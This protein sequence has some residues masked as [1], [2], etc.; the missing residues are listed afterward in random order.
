MRTVCIIPARGGSVRIPRKNIRPF[1][2]KPIMLYSVETAQKSMLFDEV[3][4]STDDAEISRIARRAGA[5][6]FWR[7]GTD[8]GAK[9]TQEVAAD[10]LRE[11]PSAMACVLYATAPLLDWVHLVQGY[12]MLTAH[13]NALPFAYSVDWCNND[14]GA[15]YWGWGAAF[16]DGID[17]KHG[18]GIS[19]RDDRCCDINTIEDFARAESMF[20]A[21]RRAP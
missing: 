17:L 11:K 21:L 13:P 8:D 16:V 15:Y 9:G 20:D 18:M 1:H 6:V 19:I 4:V 10:V 3:I 7:K 12:R 5:T 14:I 2:G